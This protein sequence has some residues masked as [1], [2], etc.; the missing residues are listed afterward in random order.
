MDVTP[1]SRDGK[2][3]CFVVREGQGGPP[4]ETTFLTPDDAIQQV[5]LV[6]HESGAEIQRHSH[7]PMTRTITGTPEVLVV[8]SG[9]CEIDVYD[10][11]RSLIATE[12]LTPGDLVLILAGGHGFRILESTVL[13]EVKQGPYFGAH[14]KEYF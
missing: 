14:E 13:L 8:R 12:S 11:E 2:T 7:L 9:L 5:G 3:Y 10:D 6:V 4:P 1:I